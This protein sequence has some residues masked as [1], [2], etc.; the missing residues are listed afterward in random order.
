V[1]RANP[2]ELLVAPLIATG[3][4]DSDVAAER[5]RTR[6]LLGFLYSTPS[7]WPSLELFGWKELGER[8]RS[9][10]REGRW[11]DLPA[12]ISDEV[13]DT[14]SP[15]GRYDEIAEVL[16]SA[17]GNLTDWITFPMPQQASQNADAAEAI[18]RLRGV[19]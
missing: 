17:Y 4:N 5:A 6:Q 12:Q 9:F 18:A 10:T 15:T 19:A 7:Y 11:D 8:L 13:L 16:S 14:F 3:V 1:A 2:V